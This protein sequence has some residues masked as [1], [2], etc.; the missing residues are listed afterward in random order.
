M[1]WGLSLVCPTTGK[2]LKNA[3]PLSGK[4][5]HKNTYTAQIKESEI[6]IFHFFVFKSMN[7]TNITELEALRLR[8]GLRLTLYSSFNFCHLRLHF[9][10]GQMT[11]VLSPD[12]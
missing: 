11:E 2:F 1:V 3:L 12:F 6:E 7:S 9:S 4:R 8:R 5:S 10:R